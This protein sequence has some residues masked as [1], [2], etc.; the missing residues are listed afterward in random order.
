M[1]CRLLPCCGSWQAYILDVE[2]RDPDLVASII[3][4]MEKMVPHYMESMM[5]LG[6]HADELFSI[7]LQALADQHVILKHAAAHF[8][9]I[10]MFRFS[11]FELIIE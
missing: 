9:V 3:N 6:P 4:L 1:V 8:W 10:S 5:R 2:S 7:S 11:G